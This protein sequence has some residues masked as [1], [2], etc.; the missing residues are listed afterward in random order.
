MGSV[1]LGSEGC[2]IVR[3]VLQRDDSRIFAFQLKVLLGLESFMSVE[4]LLKHI[5]H[6]FGAHIHEECSFSI[7]VSV[8]GFASL[9]EKSSLCGANLVIHSNALPWKELVLLQVSFN[10]LDH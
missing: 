4:V 3:D 9:S 2:T 10:I 1:G 7:H 5:F 8:L 6:S